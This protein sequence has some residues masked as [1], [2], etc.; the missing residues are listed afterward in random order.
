MS[1][2][3][4]GRRHH[5]PEWTILSHVSCF[6]E[7]EV[8]WFQVL[9]GRLHPRSTG[10]SRWSLAVLQGEAVKIC[11]ASDSPGFPAIWPNKE[12]RRAWTVAERC[13]CSVFRLTSSFQ[14]GRLSLSASL[15]SVCTEC[16]TGPTGV[17]QVQVFTVHQWSTQLVKLLS[18][19]VSTG[20][21]PWQST[22]QVNLANAGNVHVLRASK[23]YIVHFCR[24]PSLSDMSGDRT[25][26]WVQEHSPWWE[27]GLLSIFIQKRDKKL[28]I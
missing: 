2:Y 21:T 23:K 27:I 6:V 13:G 26:S 9:L 28:R 11:L 24:L 7:G 19:V 20:Q 22:S 12:R 17:R 5:S 10:S 15:W 18:A 3:S 1:A 16:Y 25:I 14:M 8:Q 4:N